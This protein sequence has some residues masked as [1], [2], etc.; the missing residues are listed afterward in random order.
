MSIARNNHKFYRDHFAKYGPI[1]KT[2]LFGVNFVIVS[3]HEAFHQFATDPRV[4]RGGTDPISVEQMFFRSL[5]LVD[6]PEHHSR[7]DVML[8]AVRTDEAMAAYLERM[9][10]V[11]SAHVDRW[12]EAG[13]AT[14]RPDLQL[15]SAQLTGCALHR[16]RVEG[17]RP[18]APRHPRGDA[19]LPADPAAADPGD[20][21]REGPQGAQAPRRADRGGDQEAPGP[22][23]AVRRHRLPHARRGAEA[24]RTGGEAARRRPAP[25]LRRA[26]RVLRAVHPADDGARPAPGAARA[27]P[28][29]GAGRLARGPDHPGAAGADGLPRSAVE[30]GPSLLRDELR[31][32]LRQGHRRPRDRRLPRP[33]GLGH[34]RRDPHQ[35]AQPRRLRRPRHLRPRA[36]HSRSAR[37]RWRR[38]ATCRTAQAS[39]TT[40]AARARTWSPS[41]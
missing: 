26:G 23:R 38:A 19:L 17:P 11:W 9:Q 28:R 34:D 6:G 32:V 21:V 40:T 13:T 29:G 20:A 14:V 39:A 12:A 22:S 30:G 25:D 18:G 4:E 2:R 8:H 16:R 7:K 24:R 31:D 5:A 10:R 33:E 15:A 1:F 36:V 41:R 35:H 3:G 37:R 27:G